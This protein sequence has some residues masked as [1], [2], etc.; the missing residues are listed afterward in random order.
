MNLMWLRSCKTNLIPCKKSTRV[1]R[2]IPTPL[3]LKPPSRSPPVPLSL[4]SLVPGWPGIASGIA[5]MKC[6]TLTQGV[7]ARFFTAS[8]INIA[9][10]ALRSPAPLRPPSPSRC[11]FLSHLHCHP[12]RHTI[13]PSYSCFRPRLRVHACT[14]MLLL[15]FRS[16][17]LASALVLSLSPSRSHCSTFA[18]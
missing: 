1:L 18:F 8:Q 14:L 4:L 12:R 13:L 5:Y 15:S 17:A 6:N 10:G 9:V 3:V 7:L 11:L 2:C 16:L